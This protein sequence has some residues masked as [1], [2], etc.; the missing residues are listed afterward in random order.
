MSFFTSDRE[1]RLWF[2]A[3]AVVAAIYSTLGPAQVVAGT[4]R[5]RGLLRVSAAV[6]LLVVGA[7]VA[8]RWMESRPG[9]GEIGVAF[10]VTFVYL[11]AMV[12]ILSPEERTHLI[13]Y[14]VAAL[15][16]HRALVERQRIDHRVPAPAV[17]TLA[18]A[19][20]LGWLDECIQ[21]L[22][23]NRV[24]DLRDVGFNALAA[25]MAIGASL[26]L[27]WARRKKAGGGSRS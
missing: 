6:V 22:L 20:A 26:A 13:E 9:W 16:I 11:F 27:S 7:F 25:T 21:A 12:R 8:W 19:I 23:P 4:L 15:L 18:V 14:G 5:D 2:W 3:L 24:Y 1:R 10:G 17:L